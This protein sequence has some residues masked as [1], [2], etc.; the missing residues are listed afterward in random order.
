MKVSDMVLWAQEKYEIPFLPA[1]MRTILFPKQ[2]N[3][4]LWAA[5]KSSLAKRKR[6][7]APS[8][9]ELEL[10]LA[11]WYKLSATPP[12]GHELREMATELWY[13]LAPKH[14]VGQKQPSFGDS[15]RDKFKSRHGLKLGS[16]S[17]PE[18]IMENE[19]GSLTG[20][21]TNTDNLQDSYDVTAIN[22]VTRCQNCEYKITHSKAR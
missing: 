16:A 8:W 19:V 2:K 3:P 18:K 6:E 15:W 11:K 1:T 4:P 9:P 22:R 14:Y 21:A 20:R 12:K 17:T 5:P 13:Q 7:R 10:E